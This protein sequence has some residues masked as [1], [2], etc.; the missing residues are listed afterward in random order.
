MSRTI[1]AGRTVA[2]GPRR[3]RRREYGAA[4]LAAALS[5]G[6]YCL[7]M[8]VHGT[9]PFGSRSRAVNDL[10]NQFV[11]FHAHLWDLMHGDS[12]GDLLFNWN[13]GYGSPFLGDFVT[14]LMNPFSWLV[15]LFPRDAVNFP[16]FLVTLLSIGLGSAVMTVFL[17]RL[18]RGSPW[19]RA[20]LAV[21]YG[22]CAWVLNDGSPDPMW[23]WGLVSLPLV[24]LACD[25]CLR[26]R[27]WVLG[28]LFV[29][30]AW[31]GNFYT[32]AM[33]T[34]GA[35]LVLLVR[36]ALTR[37]PLRARLRVLGRAAGMVVVGVL[38][39]APVMF[40][41]LKASKASQPA[42]LAR[43]DGP[44]GL[45]DY[46]AQLLPGGRS[47]HSVPNVFVGILGLVLVASLPFNRK[48]RARERTLWYVLLVLV[49][50]SFVWEPTILLWH[51]LAIPNGSSY[52]ASFVLSGLLVMAAWVSLSR[53]PDLFALLGGAGLVALIV[54]L[55]HGQSSVHTAT[56]VLVT[57]GGALM[58][59]ALWALDRWHADRRAQRLTGAVLALGVL[60]GATYSTYSVTAIRDRLTF[61]QPKTT[62]SSQS[63]AAYDAIRRADD[64]PRTRT[65]PGPHEFANNDPL[66]LGG[67]GGSYYSSYLPA[68]TAQL[69]HDLGAGW[70]IQG[71]HTLSPADPVGRAL[72]GVTTYLDS[73]SAPE[74]FTAKQAQA[75]PLVTVHPGIKPDTSSVWARQQSLLG[76]KV[77]DIPELTPTAGP[78]PTLH[79]TSGW[80]IPATPKGGTWTTFGGVCTP[81]STA[82]FYGPWFNGTVMGLGT[83]YTSYGKQPMTAM[84]IRLLGTVP[85]DGRVQVQLQAGAAAQ[86]PAQPVGCLDQG[87]LTTAL[88]QLKGATSVSAGGHGF[89]AEL[90]AGS[91]GTALLAVPAV[92]GWQCSV[93]GGARSE[94]QSVL[95]MIGVP[96][97]SGASRV[98]CTYRTPGLTAGLAVSAGALAVLG[99][100][101]L[102]TSLR[103][104]SVPK[105]SAAPVPS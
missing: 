77:Y 49:G 39:T 73:S 8:A 101:A 29:A 61:Y 51:G 69:L 20:L 97:G 57:A 91:T 75:A 85:A 55:G 67:E 3:L 46:L 53:R 104:R 100:V 86:V 34:I 17:G 33:A 71:R 103:R 68:V 27:R 4:G 92:Q 7:A 5:T 98:S 93:D 31:A 13:S 52:R 40:V 11:P 58:L 24:S 66:L 78:R 99:G 88:G 2:T 74:G 62:I 90:P 80:S 32:G 35:G 22:L 72:L 23:M 25:W 28:T 102:V 44:P 70:Y 59:G 64:W 26:E 15:G 95:G 41:S 87:A 9:Y 81:G 89:T 54:L 65:D 47:D 16:V 6:A 94:A 84:P 83:K 63:L 37:R 60:A 14:Y 12:T 43:Y 18:H 42:P 82:F 36:V 96:L 48:V 19:L 79:G 50:A 56:W 38:L 76:A 1:E 21:G 30:V 10:G 105:G 45:T